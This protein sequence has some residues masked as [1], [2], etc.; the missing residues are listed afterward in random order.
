[1]QDEPL[2]PNP[3]R[4][5]TPW[6]H[7]ACPKLAT[8]LGASTS[9]MPQICHRNPTTTTTHARFAR[10]RSLNFPHPARMGIKF[11]TILIVFEIV[12][13]ARPPTAFRRV[14]QVLELQKVGPF[15]P[16]AQEGGR[17]SPGQSHQTL[18]AARVENERGKDPERPQE[19]AG[20]RARPSSHSPRALW[21]DLR[22]RPDRAAASLLH[23][24]PQPALLWA[25]TGP[26]RS[27][28]ASAVARKALL[29]ETLSA[30]TAG[31]LQ[32]PNL[33]AVLKIQI[34]MEKL[35][36]VIKEMDKRREKS[37]PK[38]VTPLLAFLRRG[39]PTPRS[40]G[41]KHSLAEDSKRRSRAGAVRAL[42]RP[43]AGRKDVRESPTPEKGHFQQPSTRKPAEPVQCASLRHLPQ[44]AAFQNLFCGR[45]LAQNRLMFFKKKISEESEQLEECNASGAHISEILC[46]TPLSDGLREALRSTEE[47]A[48]RNPDLAAVFPVLPAATPA[49]TE[50]ASVA[51]ATTTSPSGYAPSTWM[52][53]STGRLPGPRVPPPAPCRVRS[54]GPGLEETPRA[55]GR[56]YPPEAKLRFRSE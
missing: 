33:H 30:R 38:T 23:P 50:S 52:E 46:R 54:P 26:K 48:R 24:A 51:A 10:S 2:S 20:R 39:M 6:C 22:Q 7:L 43:A 35:K 49:G 34:Q 56:T 3:V 55:S 16:E 1:M 4:S 42:R 36:S 37:R 27:C 15:A 45:Y 8:F 5:P 11:L 14:P 9:L 25:N 21:P 18:G 13:R 17:K 41:Q 53:R 19:C 12:I 29:V 40:C 32:L 31:L 44:K 28:P 47:L